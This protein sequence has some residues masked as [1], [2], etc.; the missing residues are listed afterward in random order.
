MRIFFLILLLFAVISSC[1]KPSDGAEYILRLGHQGNEK[2]IWHRSALYF[3]NALDS[4]TGGCVEVQVF[5]AEQLGAELDIIRSIRAGIVEMTITGESMQNWS[6]ITALLAVPYLIKD[7]EHLKQVVEGETGEEIAGEMIREIGLRPVGYFERG[8]RHLT[9]NRPVTHPDD[10]NG[11]ILRVPNVPLFVSV[12]QALG[13][14]P[15]P[16]A[17]SE[18]FTALQQGTVEAQEN[19]FALIYSAGLYEVQEYLNLTRHVTSWIYMVIGEKQF[20]SLPEELQGKVLL[21]GRLMQ[22]YHENEFIKQEEFL[23][24]QL[25]DQGMVFIEPDIEAFR[26]KAEDA[27]LEVL[28]DE[29]RPLYLRITESGGEQ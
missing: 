13:A 15:T 20:K 18:V 12:W 19:P 14:K 4:L 28:P 24:K 8:P 25:E 26:E 7:S 5:P 16:M 17:F 23:R 11:L 2:D 29:Y 3:A 22:K 10:L 21:A 1:R 9:S 6:G 27:V